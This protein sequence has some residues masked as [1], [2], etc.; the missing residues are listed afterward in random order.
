MFEGLKDPRARFTKMRG[1]GIQKPRRDN[2]RRQVG[3]LIGLE[4]RIASAST[5]VLDA[6]HVAPDNAVISQDEPNAERRCWKSNEIETRCDRL[7]DINK[8]VLHR[9]RPNGGLVIIEK[10]A[11]P[12]REKDVFDLHFVRSINRTG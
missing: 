9:P 5:R 12:R 7:A 8:A 1:I 10:G 4:E 3:E 11:A 2:A 6:H